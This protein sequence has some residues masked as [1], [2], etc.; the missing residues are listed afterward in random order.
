MSTSYDC[1][2]SVAFRNELSWKLK[3]SVLVKW[4]DTDTGKEL[5][6]GQSTPTSKNV[7]LILWIGRGHNESQDLLVILL[8][9]TVTYYVSAR[10]KSIN[11]FLV[12]SSELRMNGDR[13]FFPVALHDLEASV[14]HQM[15]HSEPDL[16]E[17]KRYISLAMQPT[18]SDV[19]MPLRNA[20]ASDSK[21][22]AQPKPIQGT[23]LHL[24]FLLRS[25]SEATTCCAYMDY[26]TYAATA[27]RNT[28]VTLDNGSTLPAFDLQRMYNSNGGALNAWEQYSDKDADMRL[29]KYITNPRHPPKRKRKRNLSPVSSEKA[30]VSDDV[31]PPYIEGHIHE[32]ST[33]PSISSD[34]VI[35]VPQSDAASTPKRLDH[36][37]AE[38]TVPE[39]PQYPLHDVPDIGAKSHVLLHQPAPYCLTSLPLASDYHPIRDKDSVSDVLHASFTNWIYEMRK[40]YRTMHEHPEVFSLLMALGPVVQNGDVAKF[41]DIK[42]KCTMIALRESTA[43]QASQNIS[44]ATLTETPERRV[45]TMI[46]WLCGCILDIETVMMEDFKVLSQRAA[47]WT[48]RL[49]DHPQPDDDAQEDDAEVAY[50]FHEAI[51]ISKVCVLFGN[52]LRHNIRKVS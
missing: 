2:P 46:R 25:L 21:G 43:L 33:N 50:M 39:T 7:P 29:E 4:K 15:H 31:P 32:Q 14:R 20:S 9:L 11:M 51:C 5:Y 36:H 12:P 16:P 40:L 49:R 35:V 18:S 27:L 42:A 34:A 1:P 47:A 6:L 37:L 13:D 17:Q 38:D 8:Q 28:A 48:E 19:V 41:V 10:K 45:Q 24:V 23:A 22:N 52:V 3:E 26:S 30:G 44:V